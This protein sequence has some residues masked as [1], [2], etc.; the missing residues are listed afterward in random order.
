MLTMVGKSS[1][2]P[3]KPIP[4]E[5]MKSRTLI[6]IIIGG[7]CLLGLIGCVGI[8]GETIKIT[9]EN[10]G[11]PTRQFTEQLQVSAPALDLRES[12]ERIGRATFTAF[13]ISTGS[14]TTSSPVEDEIAREVKEAFEASGYKT[15][16]LTDGTLRVAANP[17]IKIS[18]NEFWFRNYN[19]LF[20]L[21]PTWGD[22]EIT[23][24]VEN[25]AGKKLFERSLKGSGS[26]LCLQ[27]NCAFEAAVGSAMTEV[28]NQIREMALSEEFRLAL[29]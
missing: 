10:F 29:R 23:L 24:A 4:E 25:G 6:P 5:I 12:K 9:H 21:V 8:G 28:S 13:A 20:P 3:Y 15:A 2:P 22:L 18:I 27:G 1:C 16:L 14:I 11:A 26:S 17:L 7:I 19:W